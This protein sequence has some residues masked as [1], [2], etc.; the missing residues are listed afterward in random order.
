MN[1]CDLVLVTKYFSKENRR[2]GKQ[3]EGWGTLGQRYWEGVE[4]REENLMKML[5]QK[6]GTTVQEC[7]KQT[8]HGASTTADNDDLY[9]VGS[10]PF[11]YIRI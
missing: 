8:G 10:Q 7:V 4:I 3:E 2:K 1:S 11:L 9:Q 5:E 6:E